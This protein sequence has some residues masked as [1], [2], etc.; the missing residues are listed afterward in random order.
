MKLDD[1]P[2]LADFLVRCL[3]E[4]ALVGLKLRRNQA[5]TKFIAP[6]RGEEPLFGPN[7]AEIVVSAHDDAE[8]G[9]FRRAH[10]LHYGCPL[11]FYQDGHVS[12]LFF[13]RIDVQ[14]SKHAYSRVLHPILKSLGVNR[15]LLQRTGLSFGEI[16]MLT[17][18]L[19]GDFGAFDARLKAAADAL[20]IADN[21]LD[22]V[23]VSP[24][25]ERT[26]G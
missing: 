12:P 26:A 22:D 9:F 8:A 23:T 14:K 20:D 25:P 16:D 5:G 19:E 1:F 4:E 15:L 17:R 3:D 13:I 18:E 6:R 10:C 7:P 21:L 24:L 2:R 11:Y